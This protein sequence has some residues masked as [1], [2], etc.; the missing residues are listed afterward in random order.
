MK[1]LVFKQF[2]SLGKPFI[3]CEFHPFFVTI[4]ITGEPLKKSDTEFCFSIRSDPFCCHITKFCPE[5]IGKVFIFSVKI[6]S[7]QV[8]PCITMVLFC[9]QLQILIGIFIV[10]EFFFTIYSI[11]K[12]CFCKTTK[13]LIRR[14]RHFF[15]RSRFA[16]SRQIASINSSS[17]YQHLHNCVKFL[18][19]HFFAS[20]F[21]C[22]FLFFSN[23]FGNCLYIFYRTSL[24]H[25]LSL[26]AFLP[27]LFR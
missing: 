26:S 10:F 1:I 25:D 7:P 13:F 18:A 20:P 27:R 21:L 5:Q 11:Q 2:S 3:R 9:S 24:L 6:T 14:S 22:H 15:Y 4:K 16:F 19:H 17:Q 23:S 12:L 8:K